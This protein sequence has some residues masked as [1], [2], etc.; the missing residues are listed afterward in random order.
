MQSM[1]MFSFEKKILL[2]VCT[3]FPLAVFPV[4]FTRYYRLKFKYTCIPLQFYDMTIRK[5]TL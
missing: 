4:N 5:N 1:K 2:Y 3:F